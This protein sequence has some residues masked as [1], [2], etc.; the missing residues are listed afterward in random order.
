MYAADIMTQ[1]VV[2]VQADTEVKEIAGLL[3]KHRISAV[4][5]VNDEMQVVGLVSEGDLVRRVETG[6]D[7]R[8][9]WWLA[10]VLSTRD[11][12]VDYIKTHGHKAS[13]VMTAKVITIAEDMPLHEIAGLLEKHHIKG[14]RVRLVRFYY[15]Y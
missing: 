4:P 7:D 13:D 5:V 8:H 12:S 10:D 1:N 11:K 3:L 6:T 15:Y 9:S 2:S 14:H